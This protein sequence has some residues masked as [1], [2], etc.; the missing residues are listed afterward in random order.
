MGMCVGWRCVVGWEGGGGRGR[1]EWVGGAYYVHRGAVRGDDDSTVDLSHARVR[2]RRDFRACDA[3]SERTDLGVDEAGEL[4]EAHPHVGP[5]SGD[6]A[7]VHH[8][9]IHAREL[10]KHLL[11][12]PAS[13]TLHTPPPTPP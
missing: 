11:Y 8:Q 5:E 2:G 10:H 9:A 4:V 6:R 13:P 3:Q 12:T 7:P 1:G